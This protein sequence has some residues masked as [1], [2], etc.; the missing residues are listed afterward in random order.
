MASSNKTSGVNSGIHTTIA[1]FTLQEDICMK[2]NNS[3][4]KVIIGLGNTGSVIVNLISNNDIKNVKLATIDSQLRNITI[5]NINKIKY[6]PIMADNNSGSGR[7]RERGKELF[8]I[9]NQAGKLDELYD[10]CKD[11]DTIFVVTSAAGGTGS[12]ICPSV[13]S[14]LAS[15]LDPDGDFG[16][17]IIPVIVCP[18]EKNPDAYHFNAND[19]MYELNEVGI[20]SYMVFVNPDN[21]DY[22]A[23]NNEIVQA[24]DVILGN[25]YDTTDKD[26]IDASDLKAILGMTGRI[27]VYRASGSSVDDARKQINLQMVKSYQESWDNDEVGSGM[28][29]YGIK[30]ITADTAIGEVFA[31]VNASLGT[32]F[33]DS[34]KNIVNDAND[35]RVDVSLIVAGLPPVKIKSIDTEY[36][37]TA[38]IGANL[39]KSNRP[40][41]GGLKKR[42]PMRTFAAFKEA[43]KQEAQK[44]GESKSE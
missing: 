13:C 8:L 42:K 15:R 18:N 6:F 9:N 33:I 1:E 27:N 22:S 11:T 14:E 16:L 38:S 29:A 19:L 39:Q 10:M 32:K 21:E 20:T 25:T 2:G 40:A 41:V 43:Q 17:N 26:S 7:Y 34:Y 31:D 28:I 24:I 23:I 37:E 5:D 30:S 3:M 12:G 36:S 44:N 4:N 35:G